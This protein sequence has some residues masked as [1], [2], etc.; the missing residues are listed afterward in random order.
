MI[1]VL[2][3][4]RNPTMRYLHRTHRV[5]V[6]R[7]HEMFMD[8]A[9]SIQYELSKRM[10]ADIYTKAFTETGSWVH[11]CELINIVD[12][13]ELT[14]VITEF[15]TAGET[16]A[17]RPTTPDAPGWSTVQTSSRSGGGELTFSDIEAPCN[18]GCC[19]RLQF[20]AGR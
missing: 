4:G 14:R 12:P 19:L 6:A 1:R 13:K 3:T 5:S 11:A 15:T 17:S 2:Q 8:K 9:F 7:L 18:L 10:C 20:S 16:P